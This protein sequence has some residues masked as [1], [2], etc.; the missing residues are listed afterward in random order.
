MEAIGFI[1]SPRNLKTDGKSIRAFI[2]KKKKE[3]GEGGGGK[4]KTKQKQKEKHPPEGTRSVRACA[5]A[6]ARGS[7]NA[8]WAGDRKSVV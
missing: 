7:Y 4:N 1:T 5:S 2:Q 8:S 6:R 3:G